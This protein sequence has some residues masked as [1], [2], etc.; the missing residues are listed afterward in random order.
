M[1]LPISVPRPAATEHGFRASHFMPTNHEAADSCHTHSYTAVVTQSPWRKKL[2]WISQR[3]VGNRHQTVNPS[4]YGMSTLASE[5]TTQPSE[6]STYSLPSSTSSPHR[7]RRR[8][9]GGA[10]V[11]EPARKRHASN[12]V[13]SSYQKAFQD[14]IVRKHTITSLV[15]GLLLVTLVTICTSFSR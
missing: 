1:D 12:R 8:Q 5:P 9:E 6:N 4:S 7:A 3:V 13:R 11:R 14:R 15:L 10:W 2:A